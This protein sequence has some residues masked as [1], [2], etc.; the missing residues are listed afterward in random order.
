MNKIWIANLDKKNNRFWTVVYLFLLL[1]A[2]FFIVVKL[3]LSFF[4]GI[5]KMFLNLRTKEVKS[6]KNIGD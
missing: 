3:Y 6:E 5:G 2:G 4:Y 1:F